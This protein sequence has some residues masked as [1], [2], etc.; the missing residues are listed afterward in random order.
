MMNEYL[1]RGCEC[2]CSL[3]GWAAVEVCLSRV[4]S[5]SAN[6]G[7]EELEHWVVVPAALFMGCVALNKLWR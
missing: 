7:N 5:C 3:M 4:V 1:S 2:F 6:P